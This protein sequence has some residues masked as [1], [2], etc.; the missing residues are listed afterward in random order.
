M[1]TG[2]LKVLSL[3][4]LLLSAC[5]SGLEP[6]V[7]AES[8]ATPSLLEPAHGPMSGYYAVEL[9]LDGLMPPDEVTWARVGDVDAYGLKALD[10]G[11]LE[12]WVQGHPRP[13]AVQVQLG[14]AQSTHTV[15]QT[16]TYDPPEVPGL[17]HMHAVG[18]S[19]TQGTQRGLPTSVSIRMGPAAQLARQLGLYFPLPM[20]I[21]DAFQE[22]TPELIGEPPYCQPPALD[23]YQTEQAL[24]LIPNAV[25][26]ETDAFAFKM[27]RVTPDLEPHN[28][29]VGGS[30][31]GELLDGPS[32]GDIP[33]EFLSHLVYEPDGTIGDPVA[34]SQMER[35]ERGERQLIVSFDLLGNDL[36]DGMIDN[37]DFSAAAM[38]PLDTYLEDI[39]RALERMAKTQAHVFLA[40]LPNPANLPFFIAKRHRLAQE[41]LT[42]NAEEVFAAIDAWREAGNARLEERAAQ[43]DNVHVVDIAGLVELWLSEGVEVGTSRLFV[44]Q[45]GGLV[46]LDGLHF[47]DTAYGLI[48]NAMLERINAVLGVQVEEI[49][50]AALWAADRERPERLL[51]A[52]LDIT[53]CQTFEE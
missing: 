13:G 9:N 25:D 26:P 43:Y 44:E 46:G 21:A 41:G 1:S 53:S 32:E 5:A 7:V 45:Y 38:T 47:T 14:D 19:L 48:A 52:G 36:I 50:V 3:G 4:A 8:E 6:E 10:E 17:L 51:E 34:E 18:A 22:M 42:E 40:N 37:A 23:A 20:L 49:D 28:L 15:A 24:E 29:A 2:W 30:R 33:L 39:D 16:F 11:W 31:V 12:L 35:L 27:V